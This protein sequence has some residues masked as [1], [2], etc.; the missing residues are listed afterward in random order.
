MLISMNWIREYVDLGGLEIPELLKR[1]TLSTAEID[2][3]YEKGAEISGIVVGQICAVEAHPSSEKLHLLQIDTSD[4]LFPCVCG[5]PNVA[6]GLK[7][8]FATIGGSTMDGPIEAA[9]I[10]GYI[11]HGMCCSEKELG[12]SE[13]SS[14]LMILDDALPLGADIKGLFPIDDT[15]FEVDNKSLTNRPDLWGHYGIAREF[16]AITGRALKEL[17]QT[18]L[19]Y[20]GSDAVPVTID[21]PELCFRYTCLRM[22]NVSRKDSPAAMK[23]RLY[24]C[25]MRSLNFL[26]DLTNYI[27]L[28]IGQPLHAFDAKNIS[29]IVV[30]TFDEPRAFITLDKNSRQIDANTLMICDENTPVAIAG[31]MGGLDSEITEGT[32]GLVLEAACFDAT[33]IRKTITRMGLRTDASSRY[34]KSLDPE[35]TLTAVRRFVCLMTQWDA[36]AVPSSLVSDV[37]PYHYPTI[38]IALDKKYVDRYSGIDIPSDRIERTLLALGFGV[39]RDGDDFSVKVPSWRATK[40]IELKADLVEELTRIYGYDN[41]IVKPTAGLLRPVRDSAARTSDALFKDLLVLRHGLHEVHSYIW[42]DERKL[43]HLGI[44][45]EENVTVQNGASGNNTLRNSALPTLLTTINE[46]RTFADSFGIFEICRVVRGLD[47]NGLCN[48][49]RTLGLALFSKVQSEESLYYQAVAMVNDLLFAARQI[50]PDYRKQAPDHPWQHPK[51]TSAID[52]LGL[53]IGTICALHPLNLG[54]LDKNGAVVCVEIDMDTID[55]LEALAFRY[56]EPSRFPSIDY[57]L[58]IRL[59]AQQSYGQ[60]RAIIAARDI[61]HLSDI[62]VVDIYHGELGA[63]VTIR[64]QFLS[65]EQTLVREDI[66]AHVD[67]LIEAWKQNGIELC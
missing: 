66:Q 2:D 41:F 22:D 65:A 62:K 5:A 47:E 51:N 10:A 25:G 4:G 28:E 43:R 54:L 32:N 27:M 21:R 19:R 26:T 63:H 50:N 11:S 33:G 13:D 7:V 61:P 56:Q 8:P 24:Y 34:E 60:A 36:A 23:I 3:I 53:Q 31:V 17:P 30:K 15:V 9:E 49:R 40:D 48:E 46:N 35:L 1:F 18:E 12:L 52:C 39:E 14:G 67:R 42:C 20:E 58:T 64:L 38:T 37:Y 16:A 45:V 59:G 57:D 44:D 6:V 29:H 55:G